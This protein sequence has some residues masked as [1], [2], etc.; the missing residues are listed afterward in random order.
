LDADP[1]HF[2]WYELFTTDV[3]AAAAFYRDVVGL[4]TKDASPSGQRYVQFSADEI[5]VAGLMELPEEGRKQG[6]RPQWMGYV[7]VRDVSATAVQIRRLG[8]SVY[9]PATATNIGRISIVADP[10]GA[11][12]GIIDRQTTPQQPAADRKFGRIGWHELFAADLQKEVAFYCQLLG[13]QKAD[14]KYHFIDAYLALSAGEQVIAGAFKKGPAAP[15]A[16]WLF[17]FDVEDLD[18]AA[19]R[20]R[21]GGGLISCND[22][23]LPSGLWVAHCTDPQGAVFALRGKRKQT[24]KVGWSTEYQGFSSRGQIVE[25][26]PRPK[27]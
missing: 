25:P 8:G 16:Y 24:T 17:Y 21:A 26:T 7:S 12:F 4:G 5:P 1:A 14:T 15:A 11:A 13:W 10:Y 2:T 18:V 6:A 19:E 3:T 9:V 22:E 20:V 23:D 27:K